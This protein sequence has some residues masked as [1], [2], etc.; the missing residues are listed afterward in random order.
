MNT[1]FADWHLPPDR[2]ASRQV[3]HA[4]LARN[5]VEVVTQ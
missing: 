5:T 3:L 2:P 4:P 1:E